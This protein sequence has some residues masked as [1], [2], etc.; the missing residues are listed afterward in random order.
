MLARTRDGGGGFDYGGADFPDEKYDFFEG[1][2]A[3]VQC[4]SG[5]G[6]G[7]SLDYD[8]DDFHDRDCNY[9]DDQ[10]CACSGVRFVHQSALFHAC[11][12]LVYVLK[13]RQRVYAGRFDVPHVR[14]GAHG[15]GRF[16][17]SAF[18]ADDDIPGRRGGGSARSAARNH[19]GGGIHV[20]EE[21]EEEEVTPVS[22]SSTFSSSFCSRVA[23]PPTPEC[24]RRSRCRPPASRR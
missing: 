5:F 19:G 20:E 14:W 9:L 6:E 21:E 11:D 22:A 2:S 24:R 12:V 23:T 15:D 4:D 10:L 1:G 18:L 7:D 8:D 3:D 17:V 16:R 13:G